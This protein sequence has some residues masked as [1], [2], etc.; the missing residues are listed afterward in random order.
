[1]T[2]SLRDNTD[3]LMGLYV[4]LKSDYPN[5]YNLV[6]VEELAMTESVR[7]LNLKYDYKTTFGQIEVLNISKIL[8]RS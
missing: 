2:S 5:K 8:T 3:Y 4:F 1:M 7:V 6:L